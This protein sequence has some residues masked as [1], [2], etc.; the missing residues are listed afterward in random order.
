MSTQFLEAPNTSGCWVSF[1][2]RK[3]ATFI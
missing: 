2:R 3:M 1:I